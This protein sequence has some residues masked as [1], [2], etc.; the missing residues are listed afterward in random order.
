MD[1]PKHPD[2]AEGASYGGRAATGSRRA[3][4]LPALRARAGLARLYQ[5]QYAARLDS[6]GQPP[7]G[8][9]KV[10]ELVSSGQL[11]H[12]K[13]GTAILVPRD[14]LEQFLKDQ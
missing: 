10:Y 5:D 9:N 1:T 3:G 8:R 2:L 7:L 4:Q 11:R 14:A 12:V 13:A 6:D